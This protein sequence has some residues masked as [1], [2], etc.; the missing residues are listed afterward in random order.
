MFEDAPRNSQRGWATAKELIMRYAPV[1]IALS[2]LATVTASVGYSQSAL[3]LD[4]RAASLE[5]QAR[6][7][8]AAGD[9]DRALDGFEAALAISPGH[10]ALVLDLADV[11]R[12]EGLQGKALHY[13]RTVLERDPQNLAA[14]AGEG[15]ALAEKGA[16]E[17][18]KRNLARL[19][20]M[21][22][23]RCPATLSVASAIAKSSA[24]RVVTAE[25]VKPRTEVS[26]N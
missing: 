7:A 15:A 1:S 23:E 8:L 13:Y 22:G 6:S 24:P 4:P 25:A 10:P 3:P 21:C 9:A 18:A 20:G 16:I 11:A 12:A 5:A 14:I 2:L 19:E 26:A 17:K